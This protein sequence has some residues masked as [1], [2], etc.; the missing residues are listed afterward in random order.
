MTDI[1]ALGLDAV[2][3]RI[4]RAPFGA[5]VSLA[6]RGLV[7]LD[8][9]GLPAL[10]AHVAAGAD[11]K[12][13]TNAE[14]DGGLGNSLIELLRRRRREVAGLM[15]AGGTL[16][17]YLRPVGSPLYIRRRSR[18]GPVVVI[19][20]AYSW[21]P[22]EPAVAQLV[23]ASAPG[24]EPRAADTDHPAWQLLHAQDADAAWQA[25]LANEQLHRT[26]HVAATDRLGRP[27]ALEVAVGCGRIVFVPPVVGDAERCG[28][29]LVQCFAAA[30]EED[31][32]PE[33]EPPAVTEPPDWLDDHLL[34]GQ[35]G[36][37]DRLAELSGELERV[38]AELADVR[39]RH[40]ELAALSKLTYAATNPELADAVAVAFRK[41][42]FTV[43]R[44]E[45]GCLLVASEEGNAVVAAAA[46][47]AVIE[48][49]PYWLLVRRFED[50]AEPQA[51]IIVGNAWCEAPPGER[52][53]PFSDLL[54]RGAEHRGLCLLASTD[55]HAATAAL[56]ARPGDEALCRSLRQAI[57]A[58]TGPC[59]LAPLLG[60]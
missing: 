2:H 55:L 26:W 54:R 30:A 24:R 4:E 20:H 19:V 9:A 22:D 49:E 1:L 60:A 31:A 18:R 44:D 25:V 7:L 45:D 36:L 11:G 12:Y 17:S 51:G 40:E 39:A 43:E 15:A 52:E 47:A 48:S 13:T 28:Q 27:V 53:A 5:A 56:V 14:T 32:E 35:A 29:L 33:P 46:S 41:L 57:L 38:Q 3:E 6:G 37:D 21:L 50:E 34:P 16:V 42:G 58:A 8:P 59:D 23:I 10:W